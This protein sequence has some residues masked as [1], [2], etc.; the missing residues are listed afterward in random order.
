MSSRIELR[1]VGQVFRVRGDDDRA[2]RDFVA[3]DGLDLTIEAG[4][5]LTIVGPSGCGKSTI[6]DLISGLTKPRAGRSWR[7]EPITGPGPTAAWCSS[8]TRCCP[9]VRRSAT[10]SSRSRRRRSA[11]DSA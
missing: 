6:L 1:N 3:L 5:V 9:G 2:L 11:E 8:S 4:E 10:S 7:T